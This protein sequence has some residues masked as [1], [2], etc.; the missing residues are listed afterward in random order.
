MYD[1]TFNGIKVDGSG[2]AT[3]L[4]KRNGIKVYSQHSIAKL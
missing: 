4:L 3:A 1:G 2:I